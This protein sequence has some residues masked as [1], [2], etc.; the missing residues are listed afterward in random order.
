MTRWWFQISF[1]F[2]PTWGNDPIFTHIFQMD[3]NHQPDEFYGEIQPPWLDFNQSRVRFFFPGGSFWWSAGR[4]TH[5]DLDQI[6]PHLVDE[7]VLP[8]ISRVLW[9]FWGVFLFRL[10]LW[11]FQKRLRQ[12]RRICKSDMTFQVGC[13]FLMLRRVSVFFWSSNG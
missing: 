1:I 5:Q 2:T 7:G 4:V 11:T 3:W 12:T 9:S 6:L 13:F 10:L 8:G